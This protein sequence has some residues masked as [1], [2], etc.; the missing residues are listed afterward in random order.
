MVAA[1]CGS[2]AFVS[3]VP[4]DGLGRGEEGEGRSGDGCRGCRSVAFPSAGLPSR[5]CPTAM[6]RVE[7]RIMGTLQAY[8]AT[9]ERR[10][11][12]GKEQR[13]VRRIEALDAAQARRQASIIASSEAWDRVVSVAHKHSFPIADCQQAIAEDVVGFVAPR[14]GVSMERAL[15]DA[16]CAERVVG[17]LNESFCDE[18]R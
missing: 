1:S 6:P 15:A 11:W 2:A 8:L 12:N 5:A 3:E 17:E 13:E 18:R 16:G 4:V 14:L 9:L 10:G 7:E